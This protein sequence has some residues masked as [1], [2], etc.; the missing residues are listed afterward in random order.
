MTAVDELG[1][2]AASLVLATFC[3]KSMVLLRMLAIAS[4]IAFIAYGYGAG[5]WPIVA[6][7]TVMLPLNAVRLREAL[8]TR[9]SQGDQ[10]ARDGGH[11]LGWGP[12]GATHVGGCAEPALRRFARGNRLVVL[13][14]SLDW[15]VNGR[16][17]RECDVDNCPN[18]KD[19]PSFPDA[20]N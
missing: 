9:P 1:Y 11:C 13:R 20:I 2:L 16:N 7:H 6:L 10:G 18:Q 8:S 15:T 4:N 19:D 14:S 3:A 5:L 12:P 17:F